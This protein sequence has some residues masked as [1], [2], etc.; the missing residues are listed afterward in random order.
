MFRV[1][2]L[3]SI[4]SISNSRYCFNICT[5]P[6]NWAMFESKLHILSLFFRGG[7]TEHGPGEHPR[8]ASS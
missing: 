3:F 4:V 2:M 8:S 5:L 7:S 1:N 6:G